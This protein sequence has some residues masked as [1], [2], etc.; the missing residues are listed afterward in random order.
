[1]RR[2]PLSTKG[3]HVGR[4]FGREPR[5]SREELEAQAKEAIEAQVGKGRPPADDWRPIEA[6]LAE[7]EREGTIPAP[8]HAPVAVVE[9]DPAPVGATTPLG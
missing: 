9:A 2:G 7:M 1:M 3:R 8:V 5:Y 4:Y 6:R